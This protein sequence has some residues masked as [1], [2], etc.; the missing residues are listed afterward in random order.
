[1]SNTVAINEKEVKFNDAEEIDYSARTLEKKR[2][3]TMKYGQEQRNLIRKRLRVENWLDAELH[4]LYGITDPN[5]TY[6]CDPDIDDIMG[7]KTEEEKRVT[8]KELLGS[9]KQTDQV[10][11]QFVEDLLEKLESLL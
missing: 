11:Q 10:I 4:R 8:I 1:M 2:N 5:E 3:L 7:L 6:P 9:C